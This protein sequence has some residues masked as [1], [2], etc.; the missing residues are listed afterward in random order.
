TDRIPD[1]L[2]L[3]ANSLQI[4]ALTYRP[5]E[6]FTDRRTSNRRVNS[7]KLGS[8]LL[9]RSLKARNDGHKSCREI[10]HQ[11]NTTSKSQPPDTIRDMYTQEF[12]PPK[13]DKPV[14]KKAWFWLLITF[15][16]FGAFI[17]FVLA[18][19]TLVG[20]PND[21]NH[22]EQPAPTETAES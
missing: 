19:G 11:G 4:K 8:D 3:R 15:G 20:P 14:Y 5:R 6:F 9:L 13:T 16:A 21:T 18:V 10:D 2:K 22:A 17:V 1:A 7:R 12:Q